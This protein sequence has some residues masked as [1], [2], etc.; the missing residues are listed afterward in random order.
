MAGGIARH[1]Q[2]TCAERVRGAGLFNVCTVVGV[3][4]IAPEFMACIRLPATVA[5]THATNTQS[6][7]AAVVAV[8]LV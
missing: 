5:Y 1:T 2:C 4:M 8:A 7:F 3:F 6:D